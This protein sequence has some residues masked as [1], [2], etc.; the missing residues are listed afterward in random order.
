MKY[1]IPSKLKKGDEIRII[2]PSR[3][4]SLLKEETLN[5]AKENL[6]NQGYK[7][8]FSK[9]CRESDIFMSSSIKS[10]VDDVHQAFKDKKVKAI[11]TVIG[12]FNSNELLPYLDYKLIK[13]NPKI[14]CGYS[15]ITALA[16]AI[17]AKTGLV[18]YSGLHFSTW[19]MKKG[20]EYNLE[21]FNKCLVEDKK[22][23]VEASEVWSD[24]AWYRDQENRNFE[25]NEGYVVIN[26]G[27]AEGMILGGNLCT[28]NLLQGTE[29]MP[30]LSNSILF[31]EDDDMTGSFFGV[32]FN[33]NLQS[34]IHQ[35]NFKK[36]KGIVIGRFQKKTE[37]TIEKLKF[38]I[39]TKKE[40][41]SIPIIASADFGH[42]NPFITFPIGG[43]AKISALKGK[44]NIE[45]IKH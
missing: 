45:I 12:G 32:E 16:N 28:L 21:Y 8:T 23:I 33:R 27:E 42:S 3:S 29:F 6:E 24:D 18:T 7:V 13:D 9:N 35:P 15:D 10:R 22:Y 39:Q 26:K 19:A 5:L 1:I 40:L 20:F 14:L 34:L 36:V 30:N 25:K 44:A 38:I 43:T 2:A 17:T 41:K 4:L 31:I 11:F 37:M